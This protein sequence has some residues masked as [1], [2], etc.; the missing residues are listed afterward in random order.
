MKFLNVTLQGF[1]GLYNG[2][3]VTKI[4]LDFT[5]CKNNICVISGPNGVGKSTIINALNIFPDPLDNL[6]PNM[7]A[8]KHIVFTDMTN[9]YEIHI[10]YPIDKNGNR[11]VT[12]ASF[13]KNGD[14]LNPNGNITS[15]KE[16]IFNEFDLDPNYLS[17]TKIS[18]RDRGI[19]DKTPSVRKK[20]LSSIISAVDVYNN[21]YKNL[22]KKANIFKSYMNNFSDKIQRI[23]DE[24][25]LRNTLAS[26]NAKEDRL[27]SV[28]DKSKEQITEAKTII[29]MNDPDGSMQNKYNEI[30][31][32]LNELKQKEKS[33]YIRLSSLK[34]S[35]SDSD[36]SYN[37]QL[38]DIEKRLSDLQSELDKNNT[39]KNSIL[40]SIQDIKN[41]ID[42]LGIK[43]DKLNS[44]INPLLESTIEEYKKQI[45]EIETDISI[46]GISDIESV[47]KNDIDNM[48]LSIHHI[49][50]MIDGLYSIMSD[51]DFKAIESYYKNPIDIT[52]T[53][54]EYELEIDEY[55]SKKYKYNNLLI[56]IC[57]D[58][59][60]VSI[61]SDRPKGCID[62]TCPFIKEA[63]DT[64]NKYQDIDKQELDT[65][66]SIQDI[67]ENIDRINDNISNLNNMRNI[68]SKIAMIT[69]VV[70][71]NI[72]NFNKFSITLGIST[73][74]CVIERICKEDRFNEL[75]NISFVTDIGNSLTEYKSKKEILSNLLTEYKI[76]LNSE[77]TMKEYIT[78]MEAKNDKYNSLLESI[79]SIDKQNIFVN[80]MISKLQ[81]QLSK[82][83]V[84]ISIE[85]EWNQINID[86]QNF[87]ME[88]ESIKSKFDSSLALLEKI[89]DLNLLIKSSIDELEPVK[90][91][92]KNIESNMVLLDSYRTEYDKYKEKYNYID[93]LR[94]YASPTK[95]GIQNLFMSM[96][97]DKTFSI[98]N[99]ILGMIFNG[100]YKILPYKIDKEDFKIPFIGNGLPV[101]DI[102]SGSE[103]Q[104]CIMGMAINLAL[105]YISSSKYDII[106]MDEIDGGLDHINRYMFVHVLQHI[107]QI[108]EISQLFIISHS[109]ESALN[110]VDVILL[111]DSQEYIDQFGNANIIYIHNSNKE[112]G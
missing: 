82:L 57:R 38:L 25:L 65:M 32:K 94:K 111:S 24:N 91:Q 78:E 31:G 30:T 12:K 47:S 54:K 80:E 89:D 2:L 109:V 84:I 27:L 63:I 88:S 52:Q 62:D 20:I 33:L 77:N 83:Q 6:V 46:L 28:I 98:V 48:V 40:N 68:L 81:T 61:L 92:K 100:E 112:Q 73:P 58:K 35:M 22:N 37:E 44:E 60:I 87:N 26:L 14:Q 95:E 101:D 50:D 18:G 72:N 76:Q 71:L 29:S 19:A 110:N 11:G 1:I 75:R 107:C 53:I 105:A 97:M 69:D 23:G 39:E 56:D 5:K 45:D 67:S 59:K 4:D 51:L 49:I 96:Y 42:R 108:L 43:I 70:K 13:I 64:L 15:Y 90:L 34:S 85:E 36:M 8:F 104:V 106:S 102:S 103:S 55:E 74:E 3:N 17:L 10:S 66:R 79:K 9:M 21:M 93:T 99:Q 86:I 7:E 16:I 41:D